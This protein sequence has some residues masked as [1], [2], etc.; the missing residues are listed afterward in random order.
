ML[1]QQYYL[2]CRTSQH[3][4]NSI[5]RKPP[6]ARSIRKLLKEDETLA[7]GTAS[8]FDLEDLA[9]KRGLEVIHLNATDDTVANLKPNR[10]LEEQPPEIN[11]GELSLPRHTRSTLAW[12]RSEWSKILNT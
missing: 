8:G 12:L 7:N 3:P 10:V 1:A 2:R 5:I 11:K 4:C 6:P 9:Y